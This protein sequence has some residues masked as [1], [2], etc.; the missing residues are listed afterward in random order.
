MKLPPPLGPL[1]LRGNEG[2]TA[3]INQ[4]AMDVRIKPLKL[5]YIRPWN[6]DRDAAQS[7]HK[8][9]FGGNNFDCELASQKYP[10]S[11]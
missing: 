4:E 7:H 3:G 8:T 5:A 2:A 1:A 10:N 11:E 9:N 6:N